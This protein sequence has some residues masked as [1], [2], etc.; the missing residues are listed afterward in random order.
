MEML[1]TTLIPRPPRHISNWTHQIAQR[2]AELI[3]TVPEC[4]E[5]KEV[6]DI[7]M[8]VVTTKPVDLQGLATGGERIGWD[9][10]AIVKMNTVLHTLEKR[11]EKAY[12]LG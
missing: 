3:M 2:T 7:L 5:G 4:A 8:V 6:Q 12:G 11:P 1:Y 10:N 9:N